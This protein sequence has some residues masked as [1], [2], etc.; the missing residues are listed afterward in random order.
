MT[1]RNKTYT[2][3]IR[4]RSAPNK[5]KINL[6]IANVMR[7]SG[8]GHA[9]VIDCKG[10]HTARTIH[11]ARVNPDRILSFGVN[12]PKNSNEK[13]H[14]VRAHSSN[15]LANCEQNPRKKRLI[16]LDYMTNRIDDDVRE[17]IDCALRMIGKQGI[18]L[19]T[20]SQ[21][22]RRGVSY[23]SRLDTL[24][25]MRRG[26]RRRAF[27]TDVQFYREPGTGGRKKSNPMMLV[28]VTANQRLFKI[29]T[30]MLDTLRVM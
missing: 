23:W 11:K 15:V 18:L 16:Y 26:W 25:T 4:K 8:R 7:G 21:D 13:F 20:I 27:H 22:C 28:I 2:F 12:V 17:D 30:D 3:Q 24:V 29:G 19:F 14:V 10:L 1:P 6:F 5:R 9:I